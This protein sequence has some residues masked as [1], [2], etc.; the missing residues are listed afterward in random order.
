MWLER[1]PEG[2]LLYSLFEASPVSKLAF[3]VSI[4][5][6]ANTCTLVCRYQLGMSFLSHGL[7]EQYNQVKIRAIVSNLFLAFQLL[8][9]LT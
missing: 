9:F 7:R 4:L 2:R 6:E 5:F 1:T 8:L 3:S